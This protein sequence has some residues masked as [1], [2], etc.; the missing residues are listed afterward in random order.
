M[1]LRSS[2]L[3]GALVVLLSMP[4]FA[5]PTLVV[6]SKP[7]KP[8]VK[9]VET[10]TL[11]FDLQI[12]VSTAG[13]QVG[14][15]RG[16][17]NEATERT[18]KVLAWSD[19]HRRLHVTFTEVVR[20]ESTVDPTGQKSEEDPVSALV[21]NSYIVDWTRAGGL[22]VGAP[23]DGAVPEAQA[24]DVREHYEDLGEASNEMA[25]LL[26]GRKLVIGEPVDVPPEA[27]GKIIGAD[28]DFTVEEFSMILREKRT[29]QRRPCAV[30]DVELVMAQNE[31]G[32]RM[33]V[34]MAG[35]VALSLKD[36]WL[37]LLDVKGPLVA[38]GQV[39]DQ[40]LELAGTGTMAGRITYTYGK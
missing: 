35:E 18:E 17:R 5:A 22:T 3:S 25:D 34:R 33:V 20:R 7:M 36:G 4:A 13:T 21:G 39:P 27:L 37:V 29:L 26:A 31:D 30:F 11:E 24:S 32:L 19:D 23:D 9:I 6:K 38:N 28:D 40:G 2:L 15:F 12:Q 14:A 16:S 1:K 10:E 8:G